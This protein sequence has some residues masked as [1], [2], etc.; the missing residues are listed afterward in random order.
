VLFCL[1]SERDELWLRRLCVLLAASASVCLCPYLEDNVSTGSEKISLSQKYGGSSEML[2][3][4]VKSGW[5]REMYLQHLCEG[6][7][8]HTINTLRAYRSP[9]H[10]DGVKLKMTFSAGPPRCVLHL[11][12]CDWPHGGVKDHGHGHTPVNGGPVLTTC[13]V[14]KL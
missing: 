13:N 7:W 5:Q 6:I 9:Q 3:W 8:Q 12:R 14:K 4:K 10:S 1:S 2:H 11:N